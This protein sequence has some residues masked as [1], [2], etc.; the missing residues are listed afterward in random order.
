RSTPAILTLSLHD[1][2]PI[3]VARC[4]CVDRGPAGKRAPEVLLQ[5]RDVSLDGHRERVTH[6]GR[7]GLVGVDVGE[8]G[9]IAA[10]LDARSR[11]HRDRKSTRLNSSHVAISYA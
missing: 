10:E 5:L 9:P 6:V 3:S 7:D 11:G 2:L 1:A 8:A 4:E